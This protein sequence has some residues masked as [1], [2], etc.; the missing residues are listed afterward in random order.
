MK[1]WNGKYLVVRR[2]GTVPAW[3]SFVVGARDP[4][5]PAALRA[6][7]EAHLA[8]AKKNRTEPDKDYLNSVLE[9]AKDFEIYAELEGNGDPEAGPWRAEAH[10]VM[11]ALRGE[12]SVVVVFPD[13][14][15][16]RT[17]PQD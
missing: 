4:G 2:D 13:K 11:T 9:I 8:H 6:Y 3:P 7:V 12:T 14:D 10:D 15:N 16:K 17:K 5:A 1:L